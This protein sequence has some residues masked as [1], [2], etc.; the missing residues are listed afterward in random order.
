VKQ[1][2]DLLVTI[3]K[4]LAL[5]QVRPIGPLQETTALANGPLKMPSSLVARRHFE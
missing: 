5:G 4:R 2:L 3:L 1:A